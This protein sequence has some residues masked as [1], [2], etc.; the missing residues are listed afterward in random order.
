MPITLSGFVI[1][2]PLMLQVCFVKSLLWHKTTP[3][4]LISLFAFLTMMII[5][6]I[7]LTYSFV[8]ILTCNHY[9]H[10]YHRDETLFFDSCNHCKSVLKDART[11]Y[12]ETTRRSV[13]S[14]LVGSCDFWMIWN[15]VLNSGKSTIPYLFLMAQRS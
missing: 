6:H 4:L 9:F 10:Q 1:P 14:Q 15:S 11:N 13:A 8:L 3:R 2:I 7:F 12:A 5:N